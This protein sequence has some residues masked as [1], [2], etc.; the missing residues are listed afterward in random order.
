MRAH[1]KGG[2]IINISSVSGLRGFLSNAGYGA[3]KAGMRSLTKAIALEAGK[4]GIRCNTVYPGAIWTQ[5]QRAAQAAAPDMF[6]G[7]ES[8]I[9]LGR[10]G[11][12]D[13]VAQVVLFLASDRASYITGADL[14]VD[15]GLTAG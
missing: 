14:V 11:M 12:P 9:P 1:R 2:S 4:D 6:G 8:R 10:I 15:G 5:I 13:E 7:L 3:T